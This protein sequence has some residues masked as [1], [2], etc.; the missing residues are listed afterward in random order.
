MDDKLLFFDHYFFLP[1]Q[2]YSFGNGQSN[3]I[4]S[5]FVGDQFPEGD[6]SVCICVYV[7]VCVFSH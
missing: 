6:V 2:L 3:A 4:Q 5:V 1:R 7:C